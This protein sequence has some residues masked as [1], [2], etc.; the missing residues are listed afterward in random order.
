LSTVPCHNVIQA[1]YL[2]LLDQGQPK[3]LALGACMHK[4]LSILNTLPQIRTP[5]AGGFLS[6]LTKKPCF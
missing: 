6:P 3:K 5:L 1:F 4:L 2:R